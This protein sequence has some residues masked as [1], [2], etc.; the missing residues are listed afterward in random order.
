[1]IDNCIKFMV[2]VD[3]KILLIGV[4]I[5]DE[6]ACVPVCSTLQAHI[7]TLSTLARVHPS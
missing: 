4:Y 2:Y 1:M 3:W 7:R 6:Y 5:C